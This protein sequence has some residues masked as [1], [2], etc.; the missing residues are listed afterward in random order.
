MK[1]SKK[2]II[3]RL[4]LIGLMMIGLWAALR[5]RAVF[6][7]PTSLVLLIFPFIWALI[8]VIV[9]YKLKPS[10]QVSSYH[11]DSRGYWHPLCNLIISVSLIFLELPK[12][13]L[14]IRYLNIIGYILIPSV[15]IWSFI[16]W[17]LSPD[18]F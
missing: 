6:I 18:D 13:F 5:V 17:L 8:T 12:E 1:K 16:R 3:E 14:L 2:E 9:S 10:E 7:F 15:F 4:D 11:F